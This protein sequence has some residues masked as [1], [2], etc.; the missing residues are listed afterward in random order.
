MESQFWEIELTSCA[1]FVGQFEVWFLIK[2]DRLPS[3]QW[4]VSVANGL[5]FTRSPN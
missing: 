1:I 2:A 5:L 3:E 4:P